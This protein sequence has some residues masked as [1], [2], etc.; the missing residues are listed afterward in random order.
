[1]SLIAAT[2]TFQPA[3]NIK[4]VLDLAVL[5]PVFA[6]VQ[7]SQA[8][9][10]EEAKALVP[11]D[12]GELR[13]SI[14]AT[15]PVD[16]G[17]TITGSVVASADHAAYNEFGTGVRGASSPGAGPFAYSMNWPGMAAT[18]FMRPALDTARAAVL[19]EFTR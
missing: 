14:A 2:S 17:R 7:R 1:M 9:V 11:V 16:D 10:V 18:P 15:E 13:D 12:T 6:A 19:D 5:V 8:I 4:G 3:S